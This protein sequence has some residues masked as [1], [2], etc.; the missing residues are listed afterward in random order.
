V[1]WAFGSSGEVHLHWTRSE[2][3]YEPLTIRDEGSNSELDANKPV[4]LS[5]PSNKNYWLAKFDTLE[6][7]FKA[8][9]AHYAFLHS[10]SSSRI[11]SLETTVERLRTK[12]AEL[13]EDNIR[14]ERDLY[15]VRNQIREAEN[16]TTA[17]DLQVDE[18]QSSANDR[19]Q[20]R[21][22]DILE[23]TDR[24][25]NT[26]AAVEHSVERSNTAIERVLKLEY[27][28]YGGP[29]PEIK[30]EPEGPHEEAET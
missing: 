12:V 24:L 5:D 30:L 21:S 19:L 11:K 23:L 9:N 28:F 27:Q 20:S 25:R 26:T 2:T 22:L 1:A 15:D 7:R 14:V 3:C 18:Y 6:A 10:Q 13:T 8:L 17:L 16:A 29:L 4:E